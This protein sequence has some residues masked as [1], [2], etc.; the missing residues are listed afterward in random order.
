M[1][2]KNKVQYLD[3]DDELQDTKTKKKKSKKQKN[4]G[5]EAA[6]KVLG[7]IG[8]TFLSLILIVI[9]T[10]CIVA[11]ALVVY[12]MQFA[13]T[14]FDVDLKNVELSYTS[15]IYAN[16]KNGNIVEIK[17]LSG[18]ENRIW[19]DMEIIP[20]HLQDAF[21]S[22]EDQRFY[23]HE[24]VDWKRTVSVTISTLFNGYGQGGS[25]ITQQLVK[26]ITG[27]DRVTPERK[28]RE[29]FRALTL[30]TRYTKIDILEAYLNRVPLGGTVY[31]VGSAAYHYFG[32]T[33]DQLTIAESAILAGITPSPSVLNPYAD[34]AESKRKQLYVLKNMYD[35]GLITT[36]EYEEAKTEQVK[37]RLIVAGDAYGYTDP[38]YEE[39]YGTDED[40]ESTSEVE[41]E[42][43][44]ESEG[45]NEG[46]NTD[47]ESDVL[48]DDV[49][50][51]EAYRWDEYEIS[52]N[53]YVDAA[54]EQV[55]EDL[56]KAKGLT[57]AEAKEDLY[58]GGYKIY[59]NMDMEIQEK[60]EE[61]YRDP[62]NF[63]YSYDKQAIEENLIQSAFVLTDYRGTVV[64]LAGGIGDKPGD[65]CF[66]RATQ[67]I[68]PIGST[69]KPISVYGQAIDQ[70]LVTYSSMI[71]DKAIKLPDGS[72]WPMNFEYDYGVQIDG[73]NI[74][75][76]V[77]DA[78]AQSKNT[79]AVRL[80]EALGVDTCFNFLTE[81]LGVTSLDY[82]Y[83]RQYSPIALG[84]LTYG[85]TLLELAGTYQMFGS[86]G[87]YYEQKLYSVITDY[88][89]NVV[90][91]QE[92]MGERVMGADSAYIT[93]RAMMQV[94]NNP[95]SSGS[96]A[97]IKGIEVV[98]KT[99]TSN[100]ERI[101]AFA[102]LTPEYLGV[103]RL[104]YDDN[105][106]ITGQNY[107]PLGKVWHNFMVQLVDEN[108]IKTFHRDSNVVEKKYCTETGL[109]ATSKCTKTAV[110]YYKKDALPKTCDSTH[111][112]LK[113]SKYPEY[114]DKH[115][116]ET[117]LV[118]DELGATGEEE[119][120]N[121]QNSR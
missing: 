92:P 100:D 11:T 30:E 24:G 64:A 9:I 80:C 38:R 73:K 56:A 13:D 2:D 71:Y 54:I 41:D 76:P 117:I 107:I 108:S 7:V 33:V 17:R 59:L 14:A 23:E 68:L 45:E 99:G 112:T 40:N 86:G 74:Y 32:K 65:S 53:W 90:L 82:T 87:V 118:K 62:D 61:F 10:I 70:N 37:F 49:D 16:D 119:D 110:G 83:D 12:V 18:D 52:Q 20:Q 19:A 111:K 85:M 15:F 27:D 55:I 77:W 95:N 105:K 81:K 34:L 29:I 31:G 21:T 22:T 84:Q 39:Y 97:E 114:W 109:I 78:V 36:D 6:K 103:V 89:D 69:M 72:T 58:K 5:L 66:N 101:V 48:Y 26:N 60:L 121:S 88:N 113:D 116:G 43:L 44:T 63:F 94:I 75:L 1:S 102:G 93:N 115:G 120:T 57:Y 25:T 3:L 104:G 67:A 50:T 8:T 51:Y 98:G 96:Y 46:E 79:I 28:I 42:N 47:K 91:E 106:K 4:T 35:Q